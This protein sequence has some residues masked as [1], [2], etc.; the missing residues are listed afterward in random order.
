MWMCCAA[1]HRML[2]N[3]A[4]T[5]GVLSVRW[6]GWIVW[7]E[8][9]VLFVIAPQTSAEQTSVERMKVGDPS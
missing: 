1:E 4:E 7:T 2:M 6:Q 5:P 9:R 8:I 3:R